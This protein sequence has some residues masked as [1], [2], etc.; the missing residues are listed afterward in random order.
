SSQTCRREP[1]RDQ[2]RR[3]APRTSSNLM[4][5]GTSHCSNPATGRLV[6]RAVA[7]SSARPGPTFH[8]KRCSP[9]PFGAGGVKA[10]RSMGGE[11]SSLRTKACAGRAERGSA[12]KGNHVLSQNESSEILVQP[13]FSNTFVCT[14]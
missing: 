1:E 5:A 6:Q 7:A 14:P 8:I 3:L 9:R 4:P 11:F 12:R 2:E 13:R 10:N